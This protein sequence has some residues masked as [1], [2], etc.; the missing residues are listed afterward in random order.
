M[1]A[2][3]VNDRKKILPCI[4]VSRIAIAY[5]LYSLNIQFNV[6]MLLTLFRLGT[7]GLIKCWIRNSLYHII[8]ILAAASGGC[9]VQR[10]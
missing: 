9:K 6:Q 10:T 4:V 1:G 7:W 8:N 5:D 2:S 3:L